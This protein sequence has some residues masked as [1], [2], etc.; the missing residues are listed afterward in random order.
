MTTI[1]DLSVASSVS[2]DDKFPIWQNANGVTRGLPIS[3]LDGRYL[4]QDDVAALAADAKVEIFIS[5]IL[6]NPD[7][8]PTFVAGT[9]LALTLANQFF[10]VDN[11]EVF[12]DGTFQGPDQYTLIGFGLAFLSP[13]PLGVQNVY[14]RGGSVRIIGAPSDGTVTDASLAPGSNV[15]QGIPGDGKVTDIKVSTLSTLWHRINDTITVKDIQFGA[16]GDGITNDS[17]AFQAALNFA[18]AQNKRLI[19]P[20][21]DYIISAPQIAQ[22]SNATGGLNSQ[23]RRPRIEGEGSED[24]LLFYTGASTSPVLSVIG[25]GDFVD[26]MTVRGFRINRPFTTPAGVG[27]L[28]N[29][30]I[31]GLI[32]DVACTGF[33]NGLQLT[34]VN[35]FKLM[36]VNLSGNN[37]GFFAQQG[38]G[39]TTAPNLIEWDSCGFFGNVKSAGTSIFGTAVAFRNCSLEGNG[40]G[41]TPTLTLTYNGGT[42]CAANSFYNNYFEGNWGP[43]DIHQ[44]LVNPMPHGNMVVEGNVFDKISATQFVTNHIVADASSLSANSNPFNMQIRGNGFFNSGLAPHNP[45]VLQA[46]GGSGY[47]GF[48]SNDM[49]NDNTYSFPLT[50]GPA[51]AQS[52]LIDGEA[53]CQISSA[54]VLSN[55]F[56]VTSCAKTGT[57]QYT[58]TIPQLT[59]AAALVTVT[60]NTTGIAQASGAVSSSTQ[61]IV[62]TASGAGVATDIAST[63]RVK[64]L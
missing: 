26:M 39:G 30:T 4:T 28:V 11:I 5:S 54:G 38:V 56:G 35:A 49:L 52:S 50:E 42:G 27:L 20:S 31:H 61:V 62:Q 32:E 34:D 19:I 7:G 45:A 24:T 22:F 37:F 15:A 25:A 9:T 43:S 33:D 18:V 51:I 59:S 2:S 3:V 10:S 47:F 64:M 58:L 40:D 48:R 8:L 12:F 23:G 44:T 6:P 17:A 63:V 60:P 53:V 13:I 36:K 46:P 55:N 16:K 29:K 21:G 14:V 57:G 1:N 41:T